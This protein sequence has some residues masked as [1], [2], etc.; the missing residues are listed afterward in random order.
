MSRL[1]TSGFETNSVTAGI[2][3]TTIHSTPSIQTSVVRSGTYA[4][5]ITSLGSTS[6]KGLRYQFGAAN[7]NGPFFLRIYFRYAAAPSA[8]NQIMQFL[9]SSAVMRAAIEL[10]SDG[11]L[12]L[13][14]EDGTIGS[15]SSALVADT[16]YRVELMVDISGAGGA[17][18]VTARIDGTNFATASNRNISTGVNLIRIGGNLAGEAQTTG[19][20]FFDDVAVN[21]AT[22]SFQTSWPGSGKVIMLV[23]NAAGE[24]NAWLNTA[25]GAGASTNFQLVDEI[26]PNDGTDLVQSNTLNA[27]DMYN[28]TNNSLGFTDTVN[29]VS[30][31]VR[32][33]NNTSDAVTSFRV[34]AE[35]AA[36][37]TVSESADIIPNSA[38]WRTNDPGAVKTSPLTLYQDPD[39]MNW[40][41]TTLDSLQAGVKLTAAGTNNVQ[42]SALYVMVDYTPDSNPPKGGTMNLM[43]V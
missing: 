16:W 19:D 34:R 4:L 37:G 1:L 15:P 28:V 20:W 2:E 17:H 18:I 3:W 10:N 9:D 33:R 21:D 12:Q 11:T 32:M 36:G 13:R 27:V 43:G 26:P 25:G 40:S 24:A 6:I 5:E 31:M 23:P 38:T 30:L 14:D 7:G 35:K 8:A 29:L 41:K 42:V 39:A 22:G